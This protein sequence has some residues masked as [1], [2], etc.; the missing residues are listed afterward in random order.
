MLLVKQVKAYRTHCTLN[1]AGHELKTVDI[2]AWPCMHR[3]TCLCT[4]RTVL[5]S[6]KDISDESVCF[7]HITLSE[8]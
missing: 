1:P 3:P 7:E 5:V 2:E 6:S 4:V 8:I